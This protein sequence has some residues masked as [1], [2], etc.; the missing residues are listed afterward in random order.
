VPPPHDSPRTSRVSPYFNGLLGVLK[1]KG[2]HK[3]IA[4]IEVHN[5]PDASK[6]P[7]GAEGKKLHQEAIAFLRDRHGDVLVSGDYCSHDPSVVP[8]NVQVYDQHVYVG[9]YTTALYPQTVWR[10][11]FDPANPK[12]N[13]LLRRLLKDRIVPY[14]E[15]AKAAPLVRKYWCP[16]G[17][18]YHNIDIPRFDQWILEQYRHDEAQLKASAVGDFERD[19]KEAARRKIPAVCDEGGYFLPPLGSQFE[20][21]RPGTDIFDLQVDLAIKHGYWGMM[22]TTY[23]GPEDPIW[24]DVKW[25]RTINGRFQAGRILGA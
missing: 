15:F 10:K 11:D 5:E 7:Q 20:L 25:L 17:W 14:D 2:L 24:Q 6:L 13:E 16:V 3:N 1:D 12:K 8:D 19:A 9:L 22:P 18:L 4:Y 23:C 21:T